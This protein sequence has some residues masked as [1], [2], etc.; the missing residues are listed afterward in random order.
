MVNNPGTCLSCGGPLL[1]LRADAQFCSDGCR[2][3]AYRGRL[4]AHPG[5]Q[6]LA[7]IETLKAGKGPLG[8][9]QDLRAELAA[10]ERRMLMLRSQIEAEAK[11]AG[12]TLAGIFGDCHF[13]ER[14]SGERWRREERVEVMAEFS[15]Q[16]SEPGGV[17]EPAVPIPESDHE[18]LRN[19]FTRLHQKPST[20]LSRREAHEALR[21][22]N[23][24]ENDMN[25]IE[26]DDAL[27]VRLGRMTP[28]DRTAEV[29][30]RI[31]AADEKARGIE[32]SKLIR[33]PSQ[34]PSSRPASTN[35][36]AARILSAD[37]KRRGIVEPE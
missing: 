9:K 17:Q 12:K 22:S 28:A 26:S 37:K 19:A 11:S 21:L 33:G 24:L 10:C 23:G 29:A 2:Q 5:G 6:T 31:I 16:L 8:D 20:K 3:F 18:A 25:P 13:I 27:L 7:L 35:E 30:R 4:G 32:P 15:K 1:A 36:L 34:A 14:T